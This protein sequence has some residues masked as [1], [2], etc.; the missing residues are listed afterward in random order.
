MWVLFFMEET[1]GK[2]GR[3]KPTSDT[4][5]RKEKTFCAKFLPLEFSVMLAESDFNQILGDKPTF[6]TGKGP[7]SVW[8]QICQTFGRILVVLYEDGKEQWSQDERRQVV[9]L[10]K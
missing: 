3:Q 2:V 8:G 10:K 6:Q 4:R 7:S 1:F 9:N 5:N